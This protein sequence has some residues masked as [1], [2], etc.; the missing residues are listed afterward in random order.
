[1]RENLTDFGKDGSDFVDVYIEHLVVWAQPAPASPPGF[2]SNP[3][4]SNSENQ[5]NGLLPSSSLMITTPPRTN[6]PVTLLPSPLL[7]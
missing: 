7:S 1:M 4:Q 6:A 5:D 2:A 3:N